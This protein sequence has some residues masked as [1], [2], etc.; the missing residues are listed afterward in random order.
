MQRAQLGRMGETG[1]VRGT[2]NACT[3]RLSW[4]EDHRMVR[5]DASALPGG[6]TSLSFPLQGSRGAKGAKVS[7][8]FC[9][10]YS[11]WLMPRGRR[12]FGNYFMI[13]ILHFRVRKADV[14]S[15]ALMA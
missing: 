11:F 8:C 4:W 5:E 15:M 12:V 7:L 6:L 1:S 10:I 13:P 14:E 9:T 3:L 2:V